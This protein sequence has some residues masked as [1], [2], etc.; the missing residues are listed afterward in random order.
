MFT[1]PGAER[2]TTAA[3]LDL[4]EYLVAEARREVAQLVTPHAADVALAGADLGADQ[5]E[6]AAGLLTARTAMSVLVA[7]AGAGKTH[8]VA[9]F[10]RAWTAVTGGRVVGVTLSTNA[11]R[12][13]ATE[14][15]AE[16]FNVA[17]VLGRREDGSTG[18][19]APA[20]PA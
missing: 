1:D 4:E 3:H 19:H 13:M 12:V 14:G 11:A 6:V 17:Q 5:A 9:A 18:R 15:L 7:P 10:A 2:Y 16:A 20:R 8:T